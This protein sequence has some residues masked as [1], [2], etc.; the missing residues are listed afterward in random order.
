[1]RYFVIL[2]LYIGCSNIQNQKLIKNK[3]KNFYVINFFDSDSK[4]RLKDYKCKIIIYNEVIPDETDLS[5]AI[6]LY[7]DSIGQIKVYKSILTNIYKPKFQVYYIDSLKQKFQRFYFDYS[8]IDTSYLVTSFSKIEIFYDNNTGEIRGDLMKTRLTLFYKDSILNVKTIIKDYNKYKLST[9][10][11]PIYLRKD[12][13]VK[14]EIT[15]QKYGE[16]VFQNSYIFCYEKNRNYRI[17]LN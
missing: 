7:P 17:N 13:K 12:E 16:I 2:I 14:I 8:S 1:M 9:Y 4:E 10:S 5:E 15:V 11:E 3:E 6:T